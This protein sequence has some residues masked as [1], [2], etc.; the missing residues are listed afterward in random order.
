PN[1]NLSPSHADDSVP[2]DWSY[3]T[4]ELL[5][6]LPRVW[7][8]GLLY[9]LVLFAAIALPWAAIAKVEETGSA[10]GRLEPKGK[11]VKL[12][13]PVAGTITRLLIDEGDGVETGQTLIELESD[14]VRSE[15]EQL[16]SQLEGQKNRL[17]QLAVLRNQLEIALNTQQQQN[18]SQELEKQAQIEQ[19]RQNFN[20]LQSTYLLQK[21][22]KLAQ[23]DRARHAIA[24]S[25]A[26]YNQAKVNLAEAEDKVRRYRKA[27]EAG[28]ISI[29]RFSETQN[30]V[31][32]NTE[33][34]NQARS[35][36]SQAQLSLKEQQG[37]LDN[38]LHQT[39]ADIE[40]AQLRLQEQ[41]KSDETLTHSGKLA[42]LRIQ[43]QLD[44]LATQTTT[45]QADIKQSESQ[46]ASKEFQL[47][48]RQ[49]SAPESGTVFSLPDKGVGAVVQPG[50]LIAEIAPQGSSLILKAQM[51]SSEAGTLREGM[52]VKLKFDAYPFQDYGV[53]AG[54]VLRKS[55]TSEVTET[56]R[57]QV[58]TFELDIGLK[59]DCIPTKNECLALKPGD[60]ATAEVIVR[61]RRVIDFILDPFKKLQKGGLEL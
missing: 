34:L 11:T 31:K 50:E 3:A 59:R 47:E 36:I 4:K 53:V 12:E 49:F 57:G 27:F 55:P 33:R 44:N 54:K 6:S 32:V 23:V 42:V 41:Q 17:N 38:I 19:A 24:S 15:I 52:E 9:F 16:R 45:L 51:P 60:T 25:Q 8:R 37:S 39:Q 22:E 1:L 46:I 20:A 10:W 13:S 2:E 35:D 40:Q 30:L 61:S 21:E 28:A 43:E 26:A 5:D 58:T 56:D 29:D 48:Q 14:L 18:Q 7:T